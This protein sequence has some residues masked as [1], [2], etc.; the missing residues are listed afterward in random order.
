MKIH[1]DQTQLITFV[2]IPSKPKLGR[3]K[4]SKVK[5]GELREAKRNFK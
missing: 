5:R 3:N 2:K 1:N 4:Q